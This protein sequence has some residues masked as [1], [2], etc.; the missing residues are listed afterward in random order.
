[1][2]ENSFHQ[3]VLF[4]R[5]CKLLVVNGQ[6]SARLLGIFLTWHSMYLSSKV[7]VEIKFARTV[8]ENYVCSKCSVVALAI[9][10]RGVDALTTNC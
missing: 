7:A 1:M 5:S 8:F 6:R 3:Y 2:E 9:A 10:V 4:L